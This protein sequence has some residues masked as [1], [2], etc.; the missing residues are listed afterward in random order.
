MLSEVAQLFARLKGPQLDRVYIA[1]WFQSLVRANWET[2]PDRGQTVV[3][4]YS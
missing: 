4:L 1:V 2:I 3:F